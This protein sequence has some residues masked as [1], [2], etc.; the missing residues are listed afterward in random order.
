MEDTVYDRWAWNAECA[1]YSTAIHTRDWRS[2]RLQCVRPEQIADDVSQIGEETAAIIRMTGIV[3]DLIV[4]TTANLY[5]NTSRLNGLYWWLDNR[6]F[7]GAASWLDR[8]LIQPSVPQAD[9]SIYAN[10]RFTRSETGRH[11]LGVLFNLHEISRWLQGRLQS[12]EMA[13]G[14]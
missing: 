13:E 6:F 4:R 10:P 7:D 1:L 5:R 11:L 14:D 8:N 3:H 9:P 12:V 2:G